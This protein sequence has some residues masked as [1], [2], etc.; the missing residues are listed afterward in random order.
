MSWSRSAV[1]RAYL[2]ARP[3][4]AG[5]HE[6]RLGDR[7]SLRSAI[8]QHPGPMSSMTP[9]DPLPDS[10]RIVGWQFRAPET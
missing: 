2:I 6:K 1:A 9:L 10:I 8:G 4:S 3:E 7:Y 5:R